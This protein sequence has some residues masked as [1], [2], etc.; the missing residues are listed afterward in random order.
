MGL[1]RADVEIV[2]QPVSL[3]DRNYHNWQKLFDKKHLLFYELKFFGKV[4]ALV[5]Q[6]CF[7]CALRVFQKG[8]KGV[9]VFS[10]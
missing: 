6:E 1:C 9:F 7:L 5:F 8:F 4:H 3:A 2:G 10:V